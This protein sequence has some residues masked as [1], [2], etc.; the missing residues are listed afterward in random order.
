M[1]LFC[2]ISMYE[3]LGISLKW[4]KL[5]FIIMCGKRE[6]N[7]LVLLGCANRC[8]NSKSLA[9]TNQSR[10][11]ENCLSLWCYL[12]K[13]NLKNSTSLLNVFKSSMEAR[14][15][16]LLWERERFESILRIYTCSRGR[17]RQ[18]YIKMF[19]YNSIRGAKKCDSIKINLSVLLWRLSVNQFNYVGRM[20]QYQGRLCF[21]LF[22]FCF[23]GASRRMNWFLNNHL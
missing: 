8:R 23:Y 22:L 21:F 13:G 2:R 16:H 14:A 19:K 1:W 4:E 20:E 10:N 9:V 11:K 7:L 17:G 6:L 3:C 18:L 5:F 12:I 15:P